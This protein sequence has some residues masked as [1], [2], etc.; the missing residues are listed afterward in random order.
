MVGILIAAHGG[1]AEGLLSAVELIAGE[2]NQVKTIGLY[3]GDGID[4]LEQKNQDGS[5]R[6][7]GWGR[8]AGICGYLRRE[9]IQY[10]D[11][12]HGGHKES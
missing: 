4:E 3:H 2:Q 10:G 5:K 7:G 8:S 12:M 9:S 6:A 1:F 11:E